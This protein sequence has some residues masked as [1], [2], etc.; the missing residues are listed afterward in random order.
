MFNIFAPYGKK[1][2]WI[3]GCQGYMYIML[4]GI[5][6]KNNKKKKNSSIKIESPIKWR[7]RE[8][9]KHLIGKMRTLTEYIKYMV[10]LN[11]NILVIILNVNKLN[12]PI[13]RNRTKK[14]STFCL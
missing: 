9:K 1:S 10:D 13:E 3:S 4:S 11:T 7:Q 2:N 12:T 5:T 6:A 8:K 14:I